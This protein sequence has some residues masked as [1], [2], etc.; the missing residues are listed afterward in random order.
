MLGY[1]APSR[2]PWRSVMRHF[3]LPGCTVAVLPGS[4]VSG[5]AACA[6]IARTGP[7]QRLTTANPRTLPGAVDVAMIATPAHPHLRS[8]AATVV[9]PVGR[10]RQTPHDRLPNGTGQR[11][12]RQA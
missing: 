1:A 6:L 9:E 10:L 2:E 3:P 12:A 8:T 4:M 7:T 11:R 5:T